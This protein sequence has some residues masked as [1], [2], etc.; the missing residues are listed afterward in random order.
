M[1]RVLIAFIHLYQWTLGPLLGRHCRFE[2]SC[3]RYAEACITLHGPGLG[4]VLTIKRLARCH[5][6]HPGGFDQPPAPRIQP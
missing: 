1:S 5:P 4:V 6:F 3:S 2:P